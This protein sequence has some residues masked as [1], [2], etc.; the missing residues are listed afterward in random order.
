M[1]MGI[2]EL[3]SEVCEVFCCLITRFADFPGKTADLA[4]D[5]SLPLPISG[6]AERFENPAYPVLFQAALLGGPK[7][8]QGSAPFLETA[9]GFFNSVKYSP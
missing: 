4:R 5:F 9:D 7:S 2:K 1:G 3:Y 6:I 8:C